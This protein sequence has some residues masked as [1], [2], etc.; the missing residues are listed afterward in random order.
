MPGASDEYWYKCKDCNGTG[1]MDYADDPDGGLVF[2]GGC[3][4]CDGK[5]V[6]EGDE[7]DEQYG[8]VRVPN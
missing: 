6:V 7:D 1:S 8:W 4:G 5:G 2:N 3:P